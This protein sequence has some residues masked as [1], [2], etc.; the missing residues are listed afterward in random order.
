MLTLA[1]DVETARRVIKTARQV[2]MINR[3]LAY[4]NY[5]ARNSN[6]LE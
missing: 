2:G 1:D 5:L 4:G 3:I 6:K